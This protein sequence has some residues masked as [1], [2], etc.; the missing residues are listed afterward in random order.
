MRNL[1]ALA[2]LLLASPAMATGYKTGPYAGLAVGYGTGQIGAGGLDLAQDGAQ[3]SGLVGY[4]LALGALVVGAEADFGWNGVAASF[5]D[6]LSARSSGS[7]QGSVRGRGGVT[8]GPALLY[9]TAGVAIKD[10]KLEI[11]G[12]SGHSTLVGVVGGAGL[13]VQMTNTLQVRLEALRYAYPDGKVSVGDL[14]TAKF[15]SGD[16]V[17]R[18][19]LIFALN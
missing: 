16:T 17:V 3:V 12:T 2:L 10:A 11:D 8:V 14:G 15:D 4:T 1:I 7:W 18:A 13:E 6:G 9:G 5:H 19:G